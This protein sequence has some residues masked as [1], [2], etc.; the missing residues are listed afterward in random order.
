M[1]VHPLEYVKTWNDAAVKL[2]TL[3]LRAPEAFESFH[4]AAARNVSFDALQDRDLLFT[5]NQLPANGV[6][7]LVSDDE[8]EA[9]RAWKRLKV[10]GVTNLYVLD[11]GLRDWKGFFEPVSGTPHFDYARPP[12]KVLDSYPK[13]LFQ[14]RIKLKT[15][16]RAGGLCS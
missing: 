2:V 15:A 5:L 10:Q 7:V 16:R 14:P 9:V 13:D 8:A 12:T 4:L 1:F 3:D 6:V 11:Q